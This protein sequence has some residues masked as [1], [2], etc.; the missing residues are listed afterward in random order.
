MTRQ[1]QR[2][3]WLLDRLVGRI[4][5][6][7]LALSAAAVLLCLLLISWSVAMRYFLNAPV[8]WVDE[9]VGYL[10]V[11]IVMLAAGD[12]LRKGDHI[13]IDLLTQRL[14]PTGKRV[15]AALGLLSVLLVAGLFLIE[16]W[17]TAVFSRDFGL[18]S[19]G[20]LSMPIWLPQ[21]V[22]AVGGALLMLACIAGLARLLIGHPPVD[23]PDAP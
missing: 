3:V 23:E 22:I 10:L 20:Y 6:L 16:G 14:G 13:A 15:L 4:C 19:S 18:R 9:A 7:G 2:A 5:R 8:P 1:K 17:Q 12:A 11:A 21:S